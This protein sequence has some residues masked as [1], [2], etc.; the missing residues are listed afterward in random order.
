MTIII[1]L[2]VYLAILISIGI[3][4]SR[5]SRN[6]S[7]YYVA[8]KQLPSWV[9]AFST[10]ATGESAW[11]L[12]G[13]TGMAYLVGFHAIWVA[14][15]EILGVALSW[16]L[17]APPFREYTGRF[18][19]IT[20]PDYLEARF[21]DSRHLIRLIAAAI[22][23]TMVTAYM[24][25]QLTAAGKAFNSF[26]GLNYTTGILIGTAVI[27]F[28][29]SVGGFKA[30]A[31]A[32]V[33][34]G[35]LMFLS[36]ILI[37]V[38]G[39]MAIGG[40]TPLMEALGRSDPSLLWPM[41]GYGVSLEGV[42]SALG[43][44]G[45]GL[46]FLGAPQLLVR[47][48]SARGQKEI[49]RGSLMAVLIIIVFDF[50]A[51]FTGLAGRALFPLLDDPETIMP[52]MSTQLFPASFT[53]I[54]LAVVLAAIIST[55]DSL[56]IL[57]SSTI[58]RDVIQRIYRPTLSDVRA[59]RIGKITTLVIGLGAFG[60]ALTE[61]RMIFWF[62]LFAWSG[63]GVAFGP[64][65][66]CS[67]FWSRTTLKGALAGM[68]S[69]FLVTVIWVLFLKESFFGL[70][71]MIPGFLVGLAVTIGVSLCTRPP[72]GAEREWQAVYKE[73]RPGMH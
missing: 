19:S 49:V 22:I 68:L 55:V 66:L 16:A 20:V 73:L 70:Y 54:F 72:E 64:P 63:L 62:V 7:D 69:G 18:N 53:G 65:I 47:Y 51:I 41:G 14:L 43:F 10:N 50:G 6:V 15:G 9:I 21:Q 60:L 29:T 1:I 17:V 5:Q 46:A 39:I 57:A 38:V 26:A 36:M 8:G 37:P 59:S 32:D 33:L 11:L 13:L 45:I 40:W 35:V 67:L 27:L 44:V 2:L 48:I 52:T 34:Q 42:M 4:G 25:A 28:Y 24:A 71:E 56:L 3:W 58:V 12:L 31:Y 61:V 23:F 30:V